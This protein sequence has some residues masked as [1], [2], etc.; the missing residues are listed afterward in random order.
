MLRYYGQCVEVLKEGQSM[1]NR[2]NKERVIHTEADEEERKEKKFVGGGGK[3]LYGGASE[4]GP[5]RPHD[6][7]WRGNGSTLVCLHMCMF[8]RQK[9]SFIIYCR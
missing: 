1:V 9:K 2:R 3:S 4:R 5:P 8:V 7:T 6:W